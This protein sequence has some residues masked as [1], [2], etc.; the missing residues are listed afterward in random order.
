MSALVFL[1]SGVSASAAT[2]LSNVE[3]F[4]LKDAHCYLSTVWLEGNLSNKS[5]RALKGTVY[6]TIFDKDGD[7]VGNCAQSIDLGP[8]S[9][10]AF[11]RECNCQGGNNP[12]V[13][14][15]FVPR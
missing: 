10:T 8:I 13:Y 7:P 2:A 4:V 11:L 14:L 1:L 5:K 6:A 15:E 12:S 3:G 9:G